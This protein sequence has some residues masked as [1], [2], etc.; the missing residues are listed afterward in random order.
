MQGV[1]SQD[2]STLTEILQLLSAFVVVIVV[3][4]LNKADTEING[5]F[6]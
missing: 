2:P 1:G 6:I 3:V 4:I 5:C